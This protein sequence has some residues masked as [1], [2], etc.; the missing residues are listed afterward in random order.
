MG[1]PT[2]IKT[3][4]N[5]CLIGGTPENWNAQVASWQDIR[6]DA[7]SIRSM[8]ERGSK[9]TPSS[10]VQAARDQ[11]TA[12]AVGKAVGEAVKPLQRALVG[13]GST[14]AARAIQAAMPQTTAV[15]RGQMQRR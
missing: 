7:S 5:G 10:G 11:R 14:P 1:A 9:Q 13:S 8:L 3:D 12:K 4:A 6:R 15:S 2:P